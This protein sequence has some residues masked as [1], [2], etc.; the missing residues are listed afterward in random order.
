MNIEQEL[1]KKIEDKISDGWSLV[2][3]DTHRWVESDN[4]YEVQF[5]L[6]KGGSKI[7]IHNESGGQDLEDEWSESNPQLVSAETVMNI[8]V[9]EFDF[10]Y[11]LKMIAEFNDT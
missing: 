9:D 10:K 3:N 11:A 1:L 6:R 2:A 5:E 8:M 7:F 4:F